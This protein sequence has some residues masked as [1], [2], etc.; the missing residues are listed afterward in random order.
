VLPDGN[1]LKVGHRF[2]AMLSGQRADQVLTHLPRSAQSGSA[3]QRSSSTQ[4][5]SASSTP[6][7]I[8]SWS[9]RSTGRTSTCGRTSTPT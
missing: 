4:K 2:P 7:C 6:A 5:S 1:K 9:T 8:R 3:R